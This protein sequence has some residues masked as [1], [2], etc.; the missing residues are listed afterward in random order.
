MLLQAHGPLIDRYSVEVSGWDIS[1]EFFVEKSELE[2]NEQS[3]K[4]VVLQRMLP[5]GAYVFVRLLQVTSVER[6]HPVAYAAH[7]ARSRLGRQREFQLTA[8][9][10]RITETAPAGA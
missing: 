2:W 7:F 10:P 6:S 9:H 1:G 3:G 4:L 8:V 5:E